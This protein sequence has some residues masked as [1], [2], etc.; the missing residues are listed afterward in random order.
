MKK[1]LVA[2]LA[3]GVVLFAAAASAAT[4]DDVKKRGF[5]QCGANVGLLGFAQPDNAGNWRGYD[6][7]HCRAIAAAIF[8]DPNAVK[9]TPLTAPQRFVALQ[10]GEIDVLIRNTTATMSRETTLNLLFAPINYYDGQGFMVRK[11]LKVASARELK[12]A[13]ICVQAGTT[14]ELNLADWAKANSITYTPAVF[15]TS[16]EANAAYEASRCDAYTTDSSALYATRLTLK[17]PD[18]HVVLPEIISKEPFAAAVRQGDDKWF[19]LVKWVENALVIAEELGV[20][21]ANIDQMK[22]STSPDV[23]RLLGLDDNFGQ[24]LGL[25]ND[26]AYNAVKRVGNFGEIFDR[27]L[28]AGSQLKIDRGVNKLWNRGGI[29]YPVPIR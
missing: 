8:N 20:T 12:G 24:S 25:A 9:F 3:A 26:W 29:L 18:D 27:N 5:L 13:T 19:N 1:T 6:V 7:D 17:A 2:S 23:K 22:S 15:Q 4:L 11:S 10:N 21:S 16:A 28:G 14:T